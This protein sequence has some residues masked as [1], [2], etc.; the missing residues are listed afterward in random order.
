MSLPAASDVCLK[1]KSP[2]TVVPFP[3]TCLSCDESSD[4]FTKADYGS[5]TVRC[6]KC[7]HVAKAEIYDQVDFIKACYYDSKP[8]G[9]ISASKHRQETAYLS[10]MADLEWAKNEN[11]HLDMKR[12]ELRWISRKIEYE[13]MIEQSC[14]AA[15]KIQN[16]ATQAMMK[17]KTNWKIS[18]K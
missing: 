11:K 5:K 18:G 4:T 9:N 2:P 12:K 8:S 10:M 13:Q 17:K 1:W 3:I 16:E 15:M 6:V 14:N 7:N